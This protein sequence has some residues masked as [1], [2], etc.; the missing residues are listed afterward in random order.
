MTPTP[1]PST[2]GSSPAYFSNSTS[3]NGYTSI[4]QGWVGLRDV[5]I[6][7]SRFKMHIRRDEY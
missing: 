1:R 3:I 4:G 6:S 5:Q 7:R 2:D